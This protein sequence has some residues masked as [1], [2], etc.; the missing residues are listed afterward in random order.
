M[1]QTIIF[2]ALAVVLVASYAMAAPTAPLTLNEGTS[3]T[4]DLS[5]LAS[6]TVNAQGG[7]VTQVNIDALTIT[8]SWQGYFGNI[9][10]TITLDDASNNTFYNWSLATSSGE[11]YATR[12][13]TPTWSGTACATNA[14]RTTEETALGQTG[15][16]GDSVTATFNTTDHPAFAVGADSIALDSCYSTNAFSGGSH[17]TSRFHQVLLSDGAGNIVY[18]TIIDGDQTGFDSETY[19]FQLL[20]GEDE[21]SGSEGPTTYYFWVELE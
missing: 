17:D 8:Q 5:G 6:Q 10:G 19:D 2:A 15:A 21:H 13:A 1:K 3:E 18:S 4:R 14:N 11:V 9:T 12:A 7:N 20:V 16:D